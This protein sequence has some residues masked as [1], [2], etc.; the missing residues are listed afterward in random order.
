MSKKLMVGAV[1]FALVVAVTTSLLW[2]QSADRGNPKSFPQRTVVKVCEWDNVVPE[3]ATSDGFM[4]PGGLWA[5]YVMNGWKVEGYV[6][7]PN[8]D[9]KG[10]GLYAVV[11]VDN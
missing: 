5:Q 2:A 1:S 4:T 8:A 11:V 9:G 7:G 10:N 6:V 3:K